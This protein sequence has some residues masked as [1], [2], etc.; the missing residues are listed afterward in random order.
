[1]TEI[2][3]KIQ[4]YEISTIVFLADAANVPTMA[5]AA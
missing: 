3:E 4:R 1:M 2:T 5:G